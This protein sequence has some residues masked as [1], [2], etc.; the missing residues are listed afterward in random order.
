IGDHDAEGRILLGTDALEPND[1][2]H[3]VP[4]SL[5]GTSK[6]PKGARGSNRPHPNPFEPGIRRG[7][8]TLCSSPNPPSPS[9]AAGSGRKHLLKRLPMPPPDTV[10]WVAR[11]SEPQTTQSCALRLEN[12]RQEAFDEGR[13]ST[14]SLPCYPALRA[15]RS[16]SLYGQRRR[17]PDHAQD[18]A[19]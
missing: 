17:I 13:R 12:P 1:D 2:C 3:E 5:K 6:G 14:H 15:A 19:A 10:T 4:F 8:F 9:P 7:C 11:G 18:H 16:R